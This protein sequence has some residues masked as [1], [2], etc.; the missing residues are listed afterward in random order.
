MYRKDNPLEQLTGTEFP[1][2]DQVWQV[3]RLQNIPY[4]K[5]LLTESVVQMQDRNKKW[6]SPENLVTV[7]L[8]DT[9]KFGRVRFKVRELAIESIMDE[10]E[11]PM[12]ARA[13]ESEH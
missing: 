3:I 7:R 8:G 1:H 6:K 11:D 13:Y 10:F 9:V 2:T 4:E 5:Y 12:S